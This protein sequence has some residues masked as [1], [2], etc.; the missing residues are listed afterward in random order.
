M[1]KMIMS[2]TP[3]IG[4]I[5]KVLIYFEDDETQYK[6]RPAVIINIQEDKYFTIAEITSIPPNVPPKYYDSFKVPIYKY[7]EAGL[8]RMSYVKANKL[9]KIVEDKLYEF[10][11]KMDLEDLQNAINKII[12]IN[13]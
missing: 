11:G 9:H 8:N 13:E 10:L 3:N 1:R 12:E 4:D 2:N 6:S 5:Y 7:S